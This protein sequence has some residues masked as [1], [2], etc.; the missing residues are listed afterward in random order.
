MAAVTTRW[1]ALHFNPRA[2]IAQNRKNKCISSKRATL[3]VTA[4]VEADRTCRISW[5]SFSLA[6]GGLIS[7]FIL[8]YIRRQHIFS[9]LHRGVICPVRG[10]GDFQSARNLVFFS[11]GACLRVQAHVRSNKLLINHCSVY[12][13]ME[14]ARACW[15]H[16][17]AL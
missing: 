14:G 2:Y 11:R 16:A 13:H 6:R 3:S 15:L 7:V 10:L 5:T 12:L 17:S 8:L 4:C 9:D 1:P